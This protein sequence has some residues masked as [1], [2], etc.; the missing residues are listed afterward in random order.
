[1]EVDSRHHQR[2]PYVTYNVVTH[3]GAASSSSS[4]SSCSSCTPSCTRKATLVLVFLG[5]VWAAIMTAMLVTRGGAPAMAGIIQPC[6]GITPHMLGTYNFS[7]YRT[8]I[9]PDAAPTAWSD[10]L[11]QHNIAG[12]ESCPWQQGPYF[13]LAVHS[14]AGLVRRLCAFNPDLRSAQCTGSDSTDSAVT[15]MVWVTQLDKER[16]TALQLGITTWKTFVA[17]PGTPVAPAFVDG[18]IQA[19]RVS[20]AYPERPPPSQ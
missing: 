15:E 5:Y 7:G 17:T 4:S 10:G 13:L 14:P 12:V 11:Q 3:D 20:D 18:H 2:T 19:T 6:T 8:T 16:C 1:M 9:H